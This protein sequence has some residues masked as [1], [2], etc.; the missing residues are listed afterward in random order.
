M[1][2]REITVHAKG[3]RSKSI[4]S[5][6]IAGKRAPGDGREEKIAFMSDVRALA[7]EMNIP[8]MV[9]SGLSRK[10]DWSPV[11]QK[12]RRITK[13]RLI[14]QGLQLQSPVR[15]IILSFFCLICYT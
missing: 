6:S 7:D 9:T 3:L 1:T 2:I 12:L 13:K 10:A 11:P 4:A 8:I 15:K 14:E 5:E